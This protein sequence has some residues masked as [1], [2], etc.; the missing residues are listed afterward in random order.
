MSKKL[1]TFITVG[2]PNLNSSVKYINELIELG[3][4]IIELGL[5]FSDPIVSNEILEKADIESLK[6]GVTVDD[7]FEIVKNIQNDYF[8]KNNRYFKFVLKAYLNTAY[9]YGYQKFFDKCKDS[10]IDSLIF[11]D[12][13]YEEMEEVKKYDFNIINTISIG[14]NDRKKEIVS[15]SKDFIILCP[16]IN[17]KDDISEYIN[18]VN[19][20]ILEIKNINS[21]LDIFVSSDDSILGLVR[22]VKENA[23]GI[24]IDTGIM[25]IIDKYKDNASE[26]INIFVN[27]FIDQI[28]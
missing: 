3:V 9:R 2:Y 11:I 23:S 28:K 26:A 21:N 22:R 20:D 18:L 14:L 15:N 13:P 7:I 6:N 8:K 24:V 12:M 1:V 25:E 16:N 4:D 27:D 10:H 17:I 19:K 5:P